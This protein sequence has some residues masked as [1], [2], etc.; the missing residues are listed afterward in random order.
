M[1]L[2]WSMTVREG[3]GMCVYVCVGVCVCVY[4]CVYVCVC[5]IWIKKI[6]YIANFNEGFLKIH[7]KNINNFGDFFIMTISDVMGSHI[8]DL[9]FIFNSN[10]NMHFF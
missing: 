6:H 7:V 4:V 1:D 8:M 5:D 3:D 10:K 9:D 2:I